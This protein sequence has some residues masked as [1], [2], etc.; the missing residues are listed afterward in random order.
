MA[1][2]MARSSGRV[3]LGLEA[4][5]LEHE[6]TTPSQ[7]HYEVT[8]DIPGRSIAEVIAT[9]IELYGQNFAAVV[10]SCRVYLNGEQPD[11][12]QELTDE[13]EVALLPPVS[14]G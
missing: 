10:P 5:G 6:P 13:D 3:H 4:G 14:G 9:A 1:G 7:A 12:H 2:N 11:P 8:I